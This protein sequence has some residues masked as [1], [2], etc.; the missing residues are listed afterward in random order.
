M[1]P[2]ADEKPRVPESEKIK[3]E[4]GGT[5]VSSCEDRENPVLS[6]CMPHVV[7]KGERMVLLCENIVNSGDF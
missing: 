1:T 6:C 4:N 5:K 3:Q 7:R 2:E